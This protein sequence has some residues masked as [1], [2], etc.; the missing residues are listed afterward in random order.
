MNAPQFWVD[1][2]RCTGCA[3]CLIACQDR[4]ALGDSAWLRIISHE[5]G[6]FPLVRVA[7]EIVHCWHCQEPSCVAVCPVEALAQTPEGW[8]RLDGEACIGCGACIEA[9]PYQCLQMGEDVVATKCDGCADWVAQGHSPVCVNACPMR[10]LGFGA[11]PSRPVSI[12]ADTAYD[13][14]TRPRVERLIRR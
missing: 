3:A 12:A 8:V 2:S 13:L 6:A 9:C 5:M 4:A 11:L 7:F 1:T 14:G 10:A